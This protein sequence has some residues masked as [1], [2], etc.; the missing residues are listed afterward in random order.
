MLHHVVHDL[1]ETGHLLLVEFF[2][3]GKVAIQV[4]ELLEDAHLS[5]A[6]ERAVEFFE[7]F[8]M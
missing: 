2:I 1:H 8:G 5:L 4:S 3:L 6:L 7:Y